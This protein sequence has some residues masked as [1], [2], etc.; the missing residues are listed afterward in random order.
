MAADRDRA[1]IRDSKEGLNGPALWL[2]PA[3]WTA[4]HSRL[5]S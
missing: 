4:L 5:A 3:D 2:T 1:G